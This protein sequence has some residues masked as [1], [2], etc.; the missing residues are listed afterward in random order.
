MHKCYTRGRH[1]TAHVLYLYSFGDE[2]KFCNTQHMKTHIYSPQ[3]DDE[4][5]ACELCRTILQH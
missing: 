5:C 3:A 1:I 2:E 4:K